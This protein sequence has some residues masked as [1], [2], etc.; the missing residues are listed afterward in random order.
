MAQKRKSLKKSF[1]KN[2]RSTRRKSKTNKRKSKR[3]GGGFTTTNESETDKVAVSILY[4][5]NALLNKKVTL[6]E[7]GK[8]SVIQ[9][10]DK[11]FK[12]Y[13]CPW[14][15]IA[16]E[17]SK[18]DKYNC[19]KD[20]IKQYYRLRDDILRRYFQKGTEFSKELKN[21]YEKKLNEMIRQN[22]NSANANLPEN[23]QAIE[24]QQ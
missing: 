22:I 4:I 3:R 7:F 1:R 17:K 21:N 5:E 10:L 19:Y 12:E 9:T 16:S 15:L 20:K 14:S 6:D 18:Q 24:Y 23:T 13:S 8:K 2:N 11:I